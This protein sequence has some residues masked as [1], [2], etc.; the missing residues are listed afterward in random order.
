[1]T[2]T[3]TGKKSERIFE[4]TYPALV[5]RLRDKSDL[6]GLN[7]GK[8]IAAF[9]NG[10]DY[11]IDTAE[12]TFRAEVKSS[13]NRTSFSLDKFTPAQKACIAKL[14]N[15]GYGDRYKIFIHSLVHNQWYLMTGTEYYK[16]ML[17]EKRK[18]KKWTELIPISW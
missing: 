13:S 10:S 17:H 1:M 3:N 11:I 7:K 9:G 12:G 16:T 6:M 2:V 14:C 15:S 18:S 8:N 5:D 4:D